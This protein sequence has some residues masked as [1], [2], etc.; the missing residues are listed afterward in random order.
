[1]NYLE[2][3]EKSGIKEGDMVKVLRKA[4]SYENGWTAE[5]VNFMDKYVGEVFTVDCDSESSDGFWIGCYL[6]PYFIL[7]KVGN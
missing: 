3:H 6:F 1:M 2:E 4:E 5:W 7:E